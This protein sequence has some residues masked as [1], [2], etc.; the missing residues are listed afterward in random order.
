GRVGSDKKGEFGE[1]GERES[2]TTEERLSKCGNKTE[3]WG[4]VNP[5]Y[6]HMAKGQ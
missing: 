3:A 1:F 6:H 4:R 5:E 2:K